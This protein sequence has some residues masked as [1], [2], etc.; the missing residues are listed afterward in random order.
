[1]TIKFLV[2][3]IVPDFTV[4]IRHDGEI[5]EEHLAG[6]I[7]NSSDKFYFTEIIDWTFYHTF[8]VIDC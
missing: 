4:K 1:M 7:Q 2:K 6:Y 5:I 3:K 8:I